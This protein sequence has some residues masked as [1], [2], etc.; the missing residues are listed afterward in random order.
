MT[1]T[2]NKDCVEALG[3]TKRKAN[4]YEMWALTPTHENSA[5]D[6]GCG[7]CCAS[8]PLNEMKANVLIGFTG[9]LLVL[10]DDEINLS[11]QAA[12]LY[13]G[14]WSPSCDTIFVDCL[15]SL[16][17]ETH[18]TRSVFP[19]WFLLTAAEEIKNNVGVIF[20]EIDL[21]DHVEVLR[22]RYHTFKDVLRHRGAF[23]DMPTKFVIAPDEVWEK[24]LKKNSFAA[25]YYY[26]E[27][28][29]Y[30]KLA[31]L[32]GMDDVKVEGEKLEGKK[33]VVVISDNTDQISTKDCICDNLDEKDDE[34]T[35]PAVFPRPMVRRKLFEEQRVEVADRESTT[36]LGIYFIDLAPDGQLRTRLEKGRALAKPPIFC[37]D[38]GGP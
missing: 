2:A 10:L 21:K 15:I 12:F 7:H 37:Q 32:F 28:P 11:H 18:W 19:S 3:F 9:L 20:S 13:K 23:W 35:S 36:E 8:K 17:G 33:E 26:H 5:I 4:M 25:A 34:V 24:I 29:I 6:G 38:E 14:D 1:N 30:S 31:C 16:K 27:E 22:T